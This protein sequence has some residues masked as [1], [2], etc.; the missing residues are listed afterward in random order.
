MYRGRLKRDLG[1]WVDKGMIPPATA[2]VLLK[3]F[4]S[5]KS[6]FSVG[7]MLMILAAVLIAASIL[8]LVAAN[9]QEIPRLTKV[10]SIILLIWIFYL[11][12]ALSFGRG[13]DRLGAALLVLGAA[14]FGGAI[15]LIG[16]LYHLSGDTLD[17]ML[18]WFAMTVVSAAAFRSAALT[19]F[20]G[21][22]AFAVFGAYLEQYDA[23]WQGL[24]AFWPPIAGVVLAVLAQWTG[25]ERSRHIIYILLLGWC[26]WLYSL[27]TDVGVAILFVVVGALAFLAVTL[28]QSP[29]SALA[30]QRGASPAFYTFLLALLGLAFL[31]FHWTEG[32]ELALLALLTIGATLLALSLEGR[33]NGA[34]R[35]LA[36]VIFAA[37]VLYLSFVTIDSML[38]TSAFFLL[39]GLVVAV[40]AFIVVKLEK[41]FARKDKEVVQ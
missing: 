33:D 29:I 32:S 22:L 3:E 34:V 36:Y 31:H 17:A 15:A 4:D 9:W 35:Y 28:P 38:G 41:L 1:I 7:G 16:Q 20:S 6:S 23:E 24:Y 37:E 10:V 14:S 19:V 40:L 25:A 27:H 39:A 11:S 13:A 21:L 8:L 2:D 26:A 30:R 18:L 5:R 12:A